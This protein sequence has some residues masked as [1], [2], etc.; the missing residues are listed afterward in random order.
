[1]KTKSKSKFTVS[2]KSKVIA[3][4]R[5]SKNGV[6]LVLDGVKINTNFR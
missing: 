6:K 2:S 5:P 1:M 3:S 4:A